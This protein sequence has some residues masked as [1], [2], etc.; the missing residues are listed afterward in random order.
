MSGGD[1][2]E[3]VLKVRKEFAT[4]CGIGTNWNAT[5]NSCVA[6]YEGLKKACVKARGADWGWTCG[7]QG[8]VATCEGG[9]T[10]ATADPATTTPTTATT[11][12]AAVAKCSEFFELS[13]GTDQG[14]IKCQDGQT[15]SDGNCA[16]DPC[17]MITDS[18]SCCDGGARRLRTFG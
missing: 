16:K 10:T 17:D 1:C 12:G 4:V 5:S 2:S 13:T 8:I 18:G 14:K 11:G 7:N 3:Q 15:V 9:T 6:S